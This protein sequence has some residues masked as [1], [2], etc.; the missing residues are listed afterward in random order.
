MDFRRLLSALVHSELLAPGPKLELTKGSHNP[1]LN[2]RVKKPVHVSALLG[3]VMQ[4]TIHLQHLHNLEC[5][6][7]HFQT[8]LLYIFFINGKQKQHKPF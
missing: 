2:P 5:E 7:R 4:S 8:S 1:K 3:N 6:H